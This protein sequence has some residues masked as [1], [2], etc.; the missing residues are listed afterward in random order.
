[1]ADGIEQVK[2]LQER[3]SGDVEWSCS[4]AVAVDQR[5][6]SDCKF[7]LGNQERLETSKQMLLNLRNTS[8]YTEKL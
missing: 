3:P 4:A 8:E 5:N 2:L 7:E 6:R 1:M